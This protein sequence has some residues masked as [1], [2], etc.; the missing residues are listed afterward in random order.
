[1]PVKVEK[2]EGFVFNIIELHIQI[3][4]IPNILTTKEL[5]FAIRLCVTFTSPVP[6][7]KYLLFTER[8]MWGNM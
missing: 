5:L 8:E 2:Y 3:I 6:L 7:L 4:F 1:M